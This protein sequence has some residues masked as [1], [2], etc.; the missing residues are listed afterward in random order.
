[1]KLFKY[2]QF[3]DIQ[4][5]NENL[6][7]A[8]KFMKDQFLI[9]KAATQVKAISSDLDYDLRNG[10]KKA[11]TM[12]DFTPEKQDEIKMVLRDLKM[13]DEEIKNVEK[14]E[15]FV[16]LRELIKPNIGYLYNFVYMYYVENIPYDGPLG[17]TSIESLYKDLIT[18]KDLLDRLPKKFDLNFIDTS[19][20][21]SSNN[22]TNAEILSDGIDK[23]KSYKRLKKIID[24]LTSK[25]KKSINTATVIQLEQLEEIADGFEMVPAD[26]KEMV[27]KTFFGE[28]LE[29]R[30]ENKPDG[31]SNPNYGKMVYRSRLFRFQQMENPLVEFIKAAKSHLEASS[32]EGYSTRLEKINKCNDTFG[33][34]GCKVV[35]N[36]GG[37]VIVEVNSYAANKF[38]NSHCSHCIVNSES[39]WKSYLGEY[40]IQYYIYNFN[41]SSTDAKSTIGVTIKPGQ[42]YTGGACQTVNNNDIGREFKTILKNW[43]KEY[44]LSEDVWSLLQPLSEEEINRRKLAVEAERQIIKKTINDPVSGRE[45]PIT[46]EDIRRFV[47][48]NGADVNRDNGKAI[49]NAVEDDDFERVKT[50][51]E[52]GGSPNLQKG[53][54]S[55]ISKSKN[56]EMIKL[57]VTHHAILTGD[58]F[59]NIVCD[60]DALEF[61]LKAGADP[62]FNSNLPIRKVCK[63]DWKSTS[64]IGESYYGGY[65]MLLRY[66]VKTEEG[67]KNFIVKWAAEYGRMDI[68][69]DQMSKGCKTGFVE[70]FAWM[71]HTRKLPNTD[72]K[73]QVGNFL[74]ENAIKYEQKEW[75]DLTSK[76]AARGKKP[77]LDE[78]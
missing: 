19:I 5:I 74:K 53:A 46:A 71:G 70:A 37:I 16:K 4:P 15:A 64:D 31:S 40:N 56:V 48:E 22:H 73:K 27:W 23:L 36:E 62:N 30:Y 54:E 8:K 33:I 75:D 55:A 34:M 3:L 14:D 45:R 61:C 9:K 67:G 1:M 32:S 77:W 76:S 10:V 26:K 11:I 21:N 42:V 18:Y 7:K 65:E 51:L 24:T 38:L 52:L 49:I 60:D 68:I 6:D 44:N 28:M 25:L 20:P 13:T 12:K 63:G 58:V 72:L 57:L 47:K 50:I 59:N 41:I 43:E 69:N 39:F 29:D 2:N 35:Y 17:E 66:G 78:M